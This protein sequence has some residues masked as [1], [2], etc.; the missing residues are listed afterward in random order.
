MKRNLLFIPSIIYVVALIFMFV[1]NVLDGFED[2]LGSLLF[3]SIAVLFFLVGYVCNIVYLILSI[4]NRWEIKSLLKANLWMK[5]IHFPISTLCGAGCAAVMWILIGYL[6]DIDANRLSQLMGFRDVTVETGWGMFFIFLFIII[7]AMMIGGGVLL[8]T[9]TG[10]IAIAGIAR[11]KSLDMIS[12]KCSFWY[13][14]ASC[15]PIIDVVIAII[16]W[17]RVKKV[18]G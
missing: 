16:M 8:T 18:Q 17:R 6:M 4:R 14:V 12:G 10:V 1:L 3:Q 7:L 9:Q 13:G 11:M 15:I 2:S 5:W